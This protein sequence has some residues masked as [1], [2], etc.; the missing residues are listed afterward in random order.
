MNRTLNNSYSPRAEM[1][2]HTGDTSSAEKSELV[3]VPSRFHESGWKYM[4]K[5]HFLQR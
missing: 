2:R 3:L 1:L 4:N 5:H